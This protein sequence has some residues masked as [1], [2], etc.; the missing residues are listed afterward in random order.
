MFST[1]LHRFFLFC[2]SGTLAFLVDYGVLR[3]LVALGMVHWL[4]RIFSF[5]TAATFTWQF[6]SRITFKS[7]PSRFTGFSA[8]LNYMG[9]AVM[10]GSV[11]YAAYLLVMR[12]AGKTD[13]LS[14]FLAVAAGSAAGLAV[15]YILCSA[16]FFKAK[17][18]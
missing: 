4:A 14:M 12:L 3:G 8:W 16:W 5:I 6:N 15:N 10:G 17:S 2:C 7:A 1:R 13:A 18:R 11:N 9:T